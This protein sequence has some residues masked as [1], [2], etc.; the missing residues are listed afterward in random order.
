MNVEPT[1]KLKPCLPIYKFNYNK[2]KFKD[3]NHEKNAF[4]KPIIKTLFNIAKEKCNETKIDLSN[5]IFDNNLENLSYFI[6][7]VHLTI[8][9]YIYGNNLKIQGLVFTNDIYLPIFPSGIQEPF[10][11]LD[12]MDY[13]LK[14]LISFQK[15]EKEIDPTN[16]R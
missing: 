2:T 14:N 3:G 15:Y 8:S 1:K 6:N 16:K 9:K 7:N 10:D 5:Q 11:K 12:N 13:V 4:Y